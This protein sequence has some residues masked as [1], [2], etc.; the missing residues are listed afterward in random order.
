LAEERRLAQEQAMLAEERISNV[1]DPKL[2]NLE[3]KLSEEIEKAKQA[4]AQ[5]DAALQIA[6]DKVAVDLNTTKE[7]VLGQLGTTEAKLTEQITGV[8][9][10]VQTKY[11]ALTAEQKNLADQLTQQGVDLNTAIDTAKTQLSQQITDVSQDVQTKYDA[12]TAEQKNLADQLT[13]QGVDL[14]TAID[15]A[16]T[17]ISADVQTKYDTL[18]E[19]IGRPSRTVTQQDIDTITDIINKTNTGVTPTPGWE[20]Y[21]INKDGKV[22]E[23]DRDLLT[24]STFQDTPGTPWAASG[25][26]KTIQDQQRAQQQQA[27]RLGQQMQRQQR[28]GNVQQLYQM[29]RGAPDAAGQQVDVKAPELAKINYFYDVYGPSIFATPQQEQLFRRPFAQGGTVNDLLRILRSK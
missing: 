23:G 16:K 4:G 6:L 27:Q 29:M 12:L 21:D 8:S 2:Q 24:S 15:T 22:D 13:Q 10:D 25:I 19:L 3:T 20:D 18:S 5:G 7:D 26:Y 9:Q 14:N 11:D 1:I 17:E 28:V